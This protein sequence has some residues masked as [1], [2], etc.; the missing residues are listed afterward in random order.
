M[1]GGPNLIVVSEAGRSPLHV[2]VADRLDIGR[3]CDGLLVT[4][5]RVSRRHLRFEV[6]GERLVVTDLGSS[7]G[8]YLDGVR[9]RGPVTFEPESTL[10]L[11]SVSIR[12][13]KEPRS[14][15]T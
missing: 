14:A 10:T 7:N 5:E 8:T 4:D 3:E 11:G 1:T 12:H 6:V 9:L 15:S 13:L 2:H